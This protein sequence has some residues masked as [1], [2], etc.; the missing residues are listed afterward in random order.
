MKHPLDIDPG[1]VEGAQ[2]IGSTETHTRQPGSHR[3]RSHAWEEAKVEK[4]VNGSYRREQ[5]ARVRYLPITDSPLHLWPNNRELHPVSL[6]ERH[7][8]PDVNNVLDEGLLQSHLR[9]K[10]NILAMP[11][12]DQSQV[13]MPQGKSSQ[14]IRLHLVALEK[15]YMVQS[16]SKEILRLGVTGTMTTSIP[17]AYIESRE[18]TSNGR[19]PEFR[20]TKKKSFPE[21]PVKAS[22][23][24][25]APKT[26]PVFI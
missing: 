18:T 13:P 14:A 7:R 19:I 15:S 11:C 21:N 3:D 8:L 22:P 23:S 10:D 6:Q 5:A 4:V 12:Q 24:L 25:H 26:L 17:K 2:D 1:R 20:M 9:T 16:D